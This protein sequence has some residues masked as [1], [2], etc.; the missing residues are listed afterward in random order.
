MLR[1]HNPNQGSFDF[2][3]V[4]VVTVAVISASITESGSSSSRST[5]PLTRADQRRLAE[6]DR[7]LDNCTLLYRRPNVPGA[8]PWDG[9]SKRRRRPQG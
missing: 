4:P 7:A 5:E 8:K 6:E 9:K 2:V 1:R 3:A